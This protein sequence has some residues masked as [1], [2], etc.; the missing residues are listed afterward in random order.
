MRQKSLLQRFYHIAS[1]IV[2]GIIFLC[3]LTF[4]LQTLD[5]KW[6]LLD[7]RPVGVVTLFLAI[8]LGGAAKG[9]DI[10][11]DKC[12]ASLVVNGYAE[13]YVDSDEVVTIKNKQ[14]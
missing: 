8:A 7:G 5:D 11:L 10:F 6:H 1:L 4:I 3:S 14:M 12:N 9:M 13:G 2:Y